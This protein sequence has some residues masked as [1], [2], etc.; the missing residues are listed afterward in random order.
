MS[1]KTLVGAIQ[2]KIWGTTQCMYVCEKSETHYLK[3][4]AGSFCS[5]HKHLMKWNRF[6]LLHGKL[7][8]IIYRPNSEDTTIL[9]A[10][11][12]TDVPPGDFHRFEAIEDSEC[13]EIYWV[14]DLDMFD[15][16]RSDSGGIKE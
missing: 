10:G 2:S 9:E 12:F 11:Q 7:K 5:R 8:V 13:L 3:I 4:N 16:E 14:D 6:C 15:I 1:H